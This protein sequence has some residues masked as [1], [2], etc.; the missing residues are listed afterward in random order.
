E[1]TVTDSTSTTDTK[2]FDLEIDRLLQVD[3]SYQHSCGLDTE[4]T[5]WCWGSNSDG[6]LGIEP[7]GG[8]NPTAVEIDAPSSFVSFD[9]GTWFTCGL[10]ADGAI[11]CWGD[12]DYGQHGDGNTGSDN[13]DPVRVQAPETVTF[14][15]VAAGEIHTCALDT[16][17]GVW[18]WGYDDQEQLGNEAQEHSSTPLAIDAPTGV[19]FTSLE[20]GYLHNCALDTEGNV[21][22]WGGNDG[23][24][25]GGGVIY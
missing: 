17:G 15:Q 18:C 5:A 6:Q 11:W 13:T 3:A 14:T 4:G 24:Q 2:S 22:C 12:N 21:W 7:P 10:D 19:T 8:N 9:V 23:G 16:E 25:L 20:A 1:I